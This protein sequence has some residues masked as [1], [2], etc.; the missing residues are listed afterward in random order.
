MVLEWSGLQ[1]AFETPIDTL[2]RPG[3][4][5]RSR[6]S[7]AG[8]SWKRREARLPRTGIGG[9]LLSGGAAAVGGAVV[10]R[11]LQLSHPPLWLPLPSPAPRQLELDH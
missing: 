4:M 1:V 10:G 7:K 5:V 3:C 6:L 8:V 9:T 11:K 2:G